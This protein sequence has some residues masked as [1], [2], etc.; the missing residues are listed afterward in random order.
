VAVLYVVSVEPGAGKTSVCAGAARNLMDAGKTIGYLKPHSEAPDDSDVG[1]MKRLLQLDDAATAADAADGR[2][3][4]LMEATLGGAPDDVQSQTVYGAAREMQA[5]VIAVEAYAEEAPD[6]TAVYQGFGENLLGVLVNKVPEHH[7]EEVRTA[8]AARCSGAGLRLLG[9]I[10]ESRT[11]LAVSV[12]DLAE[13]LNGTII[14]EAEKADGLVENFMLGAMVVDSG[15][16][17][18]GLKERKAA[19]V[20]QDRPDMQLAALDTPS[21]CLVLGGS[22]EPPLYNVLERSRLRGVPVISTATPVNDIA[23]AID[24]ILLAG[25]MNQEQKLPR[26]AELVKESLDISTLV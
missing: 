2:D 17:Y 14:S 13:K 3:A 26:A 12:G 4:V 15:L 25:R 23:E 18:F 21:A 24:D 22:A 1:F 10:P 9:V 16:D 8:A 11:L 20:R 5:G 7:L 6:Y 19:I